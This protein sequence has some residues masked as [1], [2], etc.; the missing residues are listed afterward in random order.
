MA[1]S[2]QEVRWKPYLFACA[3]LLLAAASARFHGLSDRSLWLDE[4]FA[5]NN[6]RGSLVD[7]VGNTQQRN[8]SP[9]IYPL[10]LQLALKIDDSAASA[11][12]P[13]AVASLLAIVVLLSLPRVGID[14]RVAFLAA[15]MLAFS[16]SQI[17]YAQEVREYSLAVF[18]A[19]AM[20][21]TYLLYCSER[22]RKWPLTVTLLIAP[23]VQYGLVLLGAAILVSIF[24]ERWR[25]VSW[26]HA[27]LGAT[28]PAAAMAIGGG[29]SLWLTLRFQWRH[30]SAWYLESHFYGGNPTD[31]ISI[32]KFLL[33]NL[34][35]LFSFV[36]PG[37]LVVGAAIPS[38]L[39]ALHRETHGAASGF[40]ELWLAAIA[41][42]VL[43]AA[44][45]AHVYPLGGIRQD[46]FVAPLIALVL[47]TA[48]LSVSQSLSEPTNRSWLFGCS[49]LILISGGFDIKNNNPYREVEDI[50][51][52]ISG[53]ESGASP[54]D[55]IYIYYGARPAIEFYRLEREGIFYGSMN[56]LNRENYISELSGWLDQKFSK[57]WLVFS[58]PY[59]DEERYILDY[60]REEWELTQQ[61]KAT[62]ASLYSATRR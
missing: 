11:R 52:V 25:K 56:R 4:A 15:L 14:R 55:P 49:L 31:L 41:L 39:V 58:H 38:L 23:L 12:M 35:G 36:L 16:S 3:L 5:A 7:T 20:L 32:G 28:P 21:Y 1:R 57:V 27:L 9:I 60:L 42:A 46:L 26:R 13:S 59:K 47:A 30:T 37:S 22:E 43:A 34:Y 50:K 8:S 44:A 40:R 53:I 62:G 24:A 61:V 19:T 10:I 48:Y 33:S 29:I 17:R 54:E 6:S 2:E 45:L 18:L 51:S